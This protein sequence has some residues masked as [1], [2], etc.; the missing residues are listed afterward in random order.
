MPGEGRG[1]CMGAPMF[2]VSKDAAAVE[3]MLKAGLLSCPGCG[4]R[5][6]PHGHA[7][8]RRV[9]GP[10]RKA[11]EV[12]PRRSRCTACKVTH[13]L[14]PADL[15]ARRG[16]G[17][18]VIG[19]VLADAARGHG[20]RRIAAALGISADTVRGWLRRFASAAGRVRDFFTRLAAAL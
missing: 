16:D 6:A 3:G 17:V 2:T 7:V 1:W 5:L 14:L 20:Y 4:G 15:L 10:R 9:F 19:R 11:R 12:R 8:R 13:V 18:P